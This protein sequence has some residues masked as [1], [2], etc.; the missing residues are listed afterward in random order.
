MAFCGNCGASL[1]EG[2]AF[3][4][5][6]GARGVAA[7]AA[8]TSS[9]GAGAPASSSDASSVGVTNGSG[10]VPNLAPALA[11][12]GVM[13]TGFPF[14]VLDPYKNDRFV[15][16]HVI[17]LFVARWLLDSLERRLGNS[18]RRERGIPNFRGFSFPFV[19]RFRLFLVLALCDVP[20]VQQTPIPYPAHRRICR[21]AARL[22]DECE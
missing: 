6:C 18:D 17:F 10:M 22:T 16:F 21:Q 7:N 14:L 12:L 9:T 13:I 11:Y 19:D 20:S 3:C 8:P 4:E 5:S 2:A 15:R 1:A